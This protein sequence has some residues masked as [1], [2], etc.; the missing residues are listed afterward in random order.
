MECESS[1][2]SRLGGANGKDKRV[3][4]TSVIGKRIL[5]CIVC[6]VVYLYKGLIIIKSAICPSAK[7]REPSFKEQSGSQICS[8]LKT[9]LTGKLGIFIM[10]G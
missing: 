3:K 5:L 1:S 8:K 4:S 2:G 6:I 10:F 9:L 7:V